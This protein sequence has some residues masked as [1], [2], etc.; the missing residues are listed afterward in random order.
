MN[1][2]RINNINTYHFFEGDVT[3]VGVDENGEE[4]SLSI[5]AYELINWINTDQIREEL[6]KWLLKNKDGYKYK[7]VTQDVI[8]NSTF[9]KPK[10]NE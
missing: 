9:K 6:A 10:E 5:D 8:V 2:K 3:I 4:F 1:N 7:N